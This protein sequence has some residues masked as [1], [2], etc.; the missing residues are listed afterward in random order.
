MNISTKCLT[1][2]PEQHRRHCLSLLCIVCATVFR[3]YKRYVTNNIYLIQM[4]LDEKSLNQILYF[5]LFLYSIYFFNIAAAILLNN[6][7]C[8]ARVKLQEK[9]RRQL[10]SITRL[11]NA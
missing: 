10:M 1:C 8:T 4:R 6:V 7:C 9:G 5:S 2:N 3:K 11:V